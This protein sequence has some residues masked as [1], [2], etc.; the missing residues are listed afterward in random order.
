MMFEFETKILGGLPAAAI[1]EYHIIKAEP[2]VGIEA[3]HYFEVDEIKVGG[4]SIDIEGLR[5]YELKSVAEDGTKA[6]HE[7]L[8]EALDQGGNDEY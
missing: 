1:G 6:V 3:G 4:F 8:A 7:T 5:E 2:D